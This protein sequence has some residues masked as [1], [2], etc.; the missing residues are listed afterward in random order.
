MILQFRLLTLVA[1]KVIHFH[2]FVK[3]KHDKKKVMKPPQRTTGIE[4]ID[5]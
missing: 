1:Q 4:M 2:L 3:N 5:N